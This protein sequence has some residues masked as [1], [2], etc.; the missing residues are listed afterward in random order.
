M[1]CTNCG[2]KILDEG[3]YCPFC[4]SSI[5]C[6]QSTMLSADSSEISGSRNLT[7]DKNGK[8]SGKVKIFS[9]I[10]A[11]FILTIVIIC[12]SIAYLRNRTYVMVEQTFLSGGSYIYTYNEDGFCIKKILTDSA[13][14]VQRCETNKYSNGVLAEKIIFEA[15]NHFDNLL[16]RY[17]YVCDSLG[18]I[19][20]ESG[21][22]VDGDSLGQTQYEYDEIGNKISETGFYPD[23]TASYRAE[24]EYDKSGNPVKWTYY[25]YY[26][27]FTDDPYMVITYENKYDFWGNLVSCTA[28]QGNGLIK[29]QVNQYSYTAE[30]LSLSSYMSKKESL[31]AEIRETYYFEN[32]IIYT[33]GYIEFYFSGL[34]A[35]RNYLGTD[36]NFFEIDFDVVNNRDTMIAFIPES[37]KINGKNVT[38]GTAMGHLFLGPGESG[39]LRIFNRG[40]T[41]DGDM[42][43]ISDVIF[44]VKVSDAVSKGANDSHRW[45]YGANTVLNLTETIYF[46][47]PVFTGGSNE[48]SG[49]FNQ[50]DGTS[51]ETIKLGKYEQDSDYGN[52]EEAIEWMILDTE[53]D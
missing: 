32:K 24:Y 13:T 7:N 46:D 40:F 42:D 4:G 27:G 12:S 19:V 43:D 17:E 3:A 1:F 18:N 49:N 51:R 21:Y 26:N 20:S 47:F 14:G 22:D 10:G 44:T 34:E 30:Y 8:K 39:I 5:E 37:L 33:D 2:K 45:S 31:D 38:A 48:E 53:D 16:Y 25:D 36:D 15:H 35:T 11:V 23:G 29:Q 50:S 9:V 28:W 41:L 6:S 52:G